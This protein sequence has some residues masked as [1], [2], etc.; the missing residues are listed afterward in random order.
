M[1]EPIAAMTAQQRAQGDSP[2]EYPPVQQYVYDDPMAGPAELPLKAIAGPAPE[3]IDDSP[4]AVGNVYRVAVS[5]DPF[6]TPAEC[7]SQLRHKV[8]AIV[9]AH[10]GKLA[11]QANGG[12]HVEVPNLDWL[13]ISPEYIAAELCSQGEYVETITT[14]V[15]PMKRVH[16][17]VEFAPPQEQYLLDRWLGYARVQSIELVAGLSSLVVAGLALV[18][19]LLK[20]DT[21]TRGYYTKRLFLGVPAAI[22][23]VFFL[24][25]LIGW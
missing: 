4:E 23:A 15:G 17:L 20:V 8:E 9:A 22:I 13:G 24:S 11:R 6:T 7:R 16:T 14:S 10:L 1:E 18:F 3:W 12:R 19:G 2:Y 5:S 21:W 25:A